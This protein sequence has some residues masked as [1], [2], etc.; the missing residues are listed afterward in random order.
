MKSKR[1]EGK[2]HNLKTVVVLVGNK[3]LSS[4]L[5]CLLPTIFIVCLCESLSVSFYVALIVS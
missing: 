5:G 2:Y 1:K 4:K 3:Q